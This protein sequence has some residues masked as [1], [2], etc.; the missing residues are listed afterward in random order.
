MRRRLLQWVTVATLVVLASAASGAGGKGATDDWYRPGHGW[1]RP[2]AAAAHVGYRNPLGA[3]L[4]YEVAPIYVLPLE[5]GAG[6]AYGGLQVG[7]LARLRFPLRSMAFGLGFGVSRGTYRVD[8]ADCTI[9][10]GGACSAVGPTVE[11]RWSAAVWRNYELGFERRSSAGFTWRFAFGARTLQNENDAECK[12]LS[13]D[14][15][16]PRRYCSPGRLGTAYFSFSLG[17]AFFL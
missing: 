8:N 14:T 11:Y 6:V 16:P 17:Y 7:A 5:V 4:S 12:A 9:A 15:E 3:G 2:F 10:F 13:G 1:E